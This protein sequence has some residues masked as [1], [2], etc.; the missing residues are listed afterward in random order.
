MRNPADIC[1]VFRLPEA[2]TLS[3][4]PGRHRPCLHGCLL[5]IDRDFVVTVEGKTRELVFEQ[6]RRFLRLANKGHGRQLITA[7]LGYRMGPRET[8]HVAVE[9]DV[10][11]STTPI[12]PDIGDHIR[13]RGNVRTF[14]SFK[15]RAVSI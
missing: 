7:T 10:V 12:P 2:L 13:P 15:P 14:T 8:V 1:L 5:D 4:L 3:V 11:F 6:A 9:A